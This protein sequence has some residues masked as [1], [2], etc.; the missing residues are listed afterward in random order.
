VR[1]EPD[2]VP[3]I[4]QAAATL[5]A[6]ATE[7][8]IAGTLSVIE[9]ISAVESLH[10]LNAPTLGRELYRVWTLHN[11]AHPLLYAVLFNYGVLCADAGETGAAIGAY[12]E[13]C[14]RKPD[15]LA[16]RINL[17]TVKERSGDPAAAVGEWYAAAQAPV[18]LSGDTLG[19]KVS[20]W[21][22]AGRVLEAG[23]CEEA[24]ETAL[25]R[26]LDLD[27]TQRDALQHWIALRQAQCKWPSLEAF[28]RLRRA[29][30]LRAISP[31]SLAAAADDPVLQ[32]ASAH[33]YYQQD[34]APAAPAT[35]GPWPA[36][37]REEA[38]RLRI[39]YL[40]SDLRDHAV[41]FLSAEI[42]EH[43]DRSRVEAHAYFSG[44][45]TNDAT[46]TRIR[47]TVDRW[48][49]ITAL[50]DRQAAATI[51][52][53]GIDILIDLNGY[54]KDGRTKL[55]ALRPAPVIVNWLG[56]PGTMGSP[57]H[58]YIIADPVTIP[59]GDECYYTEKVL[60]LPC[61]QPNDRKRVT[62]PDTPTRAA[63][64]LP[65]T[66]M[67]YCCFNGPNKITRLVFDRW[68]QILRAV[69]DSVLWLL[70]SND[71]TEQ[72]LRAH[73]ES[74]GVAGQRLVFAGR[75]RTA[76]HLARYRIADLF[77]DTSPYGAHTTASDALWGGVPVLTFLGRCFAA[78][79]CGSLVRAAGL[80]DLV[81]DTP[82]QY[83]GEAI[84]I[85]L[86]ADLRHGL[87]QRLRMMRQRCLLFDTPL[88]VSKLEDLFVQM[89]QEYQRG[90]LPLP[91]L[92][93]L[94]L[95]GEIGCEI[96]HDSPPWRV[97]GDLRA[98]YGSQMAY[99]NAMSPLPADSRLWPGAQAGMA[100]A[101]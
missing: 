25:R 32:L 46:Q 72:R 89:W 68:M 43:H 26:C 73:A 88:L 86:D 10:A 13:A 14:A 8:A 37:D 45:A 50:T 93:N 47:Q 36:P 101:A 24:A 77:L 83:V 2:Q 22:Q 40:S 35:S 55:V 64:G 27:P 94:P 16:A 66:A 79:V 63:C 15:F 85:G 28:G 78:R 61:Y 96:D 95:Y 74:C 49:D 62:A 65:E 56:F 34:V 41:G 44:L 7:S 23:R 12:E 17:G 60:R 3:D 71:A 53:D 20:A 99:R 75:M 33:R 48:T 84:R 69:P 57:H 54:T 91:E 90:D 4:N 97:T 92:V 58:N 67:V 21:K 39:G 80:P 52:R 18:E 51:V 70:Q 5:S 98:W 31:L 9:L 19:W 6:Q 42:F 1:E 100:R 38:R 11:Q 82:D 30:F 87:K 29:D 59:R 81:C 76:E